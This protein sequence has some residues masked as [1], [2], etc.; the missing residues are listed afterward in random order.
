MVRTRMVFVSITSG[1]KHLSL[2]LVSGLEKV[3]KVGEGEVNTCN[4]SCQ[5]SQDCRHSKEQNFE[6]R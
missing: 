6:Q 3:K 1:G 2:S 4:Y 5:N